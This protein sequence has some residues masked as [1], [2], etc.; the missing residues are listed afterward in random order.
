MFYPGDPVA[1]STEIDRL[2]AETDVPA[3]SGEIIGMV[4][5]HA[6]YVYSGSCAAAAYI[7]LR[8]KRYDIVTVI[9]PSHRKFFDHAA[10]F[11]GAAYDTPL[12]RIHC[13]RAIADAMSGVHPKVVL[14]DFGHSSGVQ[15]EHALEVQLP[16]LQK[17][18]G[19]FKLVPIVMGNQEWS[20]SIALGEAISSALQ[21]KRA[22]IVASSDL[23]HYHNAGE[24]R[25]MDEGIKTAVEK[26]DWKLLFD[27]VA[28]GTSEACGAGPVVAAM[29]ACKRLGA[30]KASVLKYTHS[31]M[32]TDDNKEVVGYLSAIFHR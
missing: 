7:Q 19:D 2:L 18:L 32:V 8:G 29:Y 6:G 17:V 14:S 13:D 28:S 25:E 16:F 23:S 31:G 5:P 26:F 20:Q 1:L 30:T 11:H 3:V 9:S 21:D 12:G 24:A 27:R 15:A 4:S 22:L 10:V